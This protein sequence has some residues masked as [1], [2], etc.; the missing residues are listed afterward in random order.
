VRAVKDESLKEQ[1]RQIVSAWKTLDRPLDL[2]DSERERFTRI[3]IANAAEFKG[4][5]LPL[6]DEDPVIDWWP[7]D[8]I[9][10][11]YDYLRKN[12]PFVF[13]GTRSGALSTAD[14]LKHATGEGRIAVWVEAVLGGGGRYRWPASW[15][16]VHGLK[17]AAH[18]VHLA[19]LHKLNEVGLNLRHHA[20]TS[21]FPWA[22]EHLQDRLEEWMSVAFANRSAFVRATPAE[23]HIERL[24]EYVLLRRALVLSQWALVEVSAVRRGLTALP[25]G[26]S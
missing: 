14:A 11:R 8:Q 17:K 20:C 4:G 12:G 24:V 25:G 9:E 10:Y 26:D 5:R 18:H 13:W 15:D 6:E 3:R 7:L 23:H 21:A 1:W 19:A 22:Q 16:E 2:D